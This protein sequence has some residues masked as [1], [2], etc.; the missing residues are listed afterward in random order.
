MKKIIMVFAIVFTFM[1]SGCATAQQIHVVEKPNSFNS[2]KTQTPVDTSNMILVQGEAEGFLIRFFDKTPKKIKKI[3]TNVIPGINVDL[4]QVAFIPGTGKEKTGIPDPLIPIKDGFFDSSSGVSLIYIRVTTTH[5]TPPE[6]YNLNIRI[7][8]QNNNILKKITQKIEVVDFKIPENSNESLTLR[9][10]LR[11]F[12]N[13]IKT[14]KERAIE[15]INLLSKYRINSM[16]TSGFET[17]EE[18]EEILFEMF[19][20]NNYKYIAFPP[21]SVVGK[22]G[23]EK[24]I[25]GGDVAISEHVKKE[26]QH[27][28]KYPI[29]QNYTGKISYQ[30]AD[31]PEYDKM[32]IVCKLYDQMKNARPDLS[33]ELTNLDYREPM[34]DSVDRWYLRT[35][36]FPN[37][38]EDYLYL[39]GLGTPEIGLYINDWQKIEKKINPMRMIGWVLWAKYLDAYLIYGV[40]AY[41]SIDPWKDKMLHT[42]QTG[43]SGMP[44]FVYL[45][46]KTNEIIPSLRLEMF[47]DGIED[48]EILKKTELENPDKG[49]VFNALRDVVNNALKSNKGEIEDMKE[50]KTIL[51]K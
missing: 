22:K 3:G 26:V 1:C 5:Q 25:A 21:R 51:L 8:N 46:P 38:H 34:P 6:T 20:K 2:L 30:L 37:K 35:I 39:R 41:G 19:D 11:A 28:E 17:Q 40:N 50:I 12:D 23:Y 13:D 47:R 32:E 14:K 4:F 10:K 42:A 27:L 36:A 31:E 44:V 15:A 18:L 9:T 49:E 29:L 45:H 24:F 7:R 33:L 48:Y 16:A 43:Y